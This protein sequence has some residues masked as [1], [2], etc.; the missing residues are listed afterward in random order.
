MVN[1]VQRINKIIEEINNKGSLKVED[2]SNYFKVSKM[3]ITRDL[4]ELSKKGYLKKIYGGAVKISGLSVDAY[5]SRLKKNVSEKERIAK[6]ALQF[7]EN[8]KSYFIST[9][10]TLLQ[11]MKIWPTNIECNILT[12]G[13]NMV[14]PEVLNSLK[15]AE[16]HSTGGILNKEYL[17]MVGPSAENEIFNRIIDVAFLSCFG[18]SDELDI[19]EPDIFQCNILKKARDRSKVKV[20]LIDHSKFGIAKGFKCYN[21]ND[22]IDYL[23]SSSKVPQRFI[24]KISKTNVKL[25]LSD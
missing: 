18:V 10:T 17:A 19:Y 2:L 22:G 7:I 11:L 20:F 24:D 5:S 12:N 9:G 1:R 8:G 4:S 21:L 16:V 13:I 14:L 25:L 15:N 23:I 3:T 6:L